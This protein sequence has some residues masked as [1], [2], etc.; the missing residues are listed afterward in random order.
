[1]GTQE[2]EGQRSSD[3]AQDREERKSLH[4]I[5]KLLLPY[6]KKG[7]F[8]Q[9]FVLQ[10][11]CTDLGGVVWIILVWEGNIRIMFIIFL[12]K[13]KTSSTKINTYADE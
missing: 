3:K 11:R 7:S 1:M 2:V 12:K 10:I 8:F 5:K 4:R 13:I 6:S 9:A